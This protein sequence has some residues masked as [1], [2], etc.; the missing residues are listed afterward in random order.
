MTRGLLGRRY[1]PNAPLKKRGVLS[2]GLFRSF[3][4][5]L[6]SALFSVRNSV[7]VLRPSNYMIPDPGQVLYATT[8]DEHNRVLLKV[9]TNAW[10]IRRDFVAVCKTNS[11]NLTQGGIRFFGCGCIH[12]YTDTTALRAVGQSWGRCFSSRPRS[13]FSD[14]LVNRWHS[15]LPPNMY[16][17]IMSKT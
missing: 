11:C 10:N 17:S 4:S 6:G 7:G 16:H 13:S 1:V 3:C 8:S 2:R 12:P 5:V 9:V 15:P 14:Q